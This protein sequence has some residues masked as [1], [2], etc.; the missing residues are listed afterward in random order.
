M[1]TGP[2]QTQ[3]NVQSKVSLNT[4]ALNDESSVRERTLVRKVSKV[5]VLQTA[6]KIENERVLSEQRLVPLK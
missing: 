1:P 2:S 5:S 3:S 4:V 6:R